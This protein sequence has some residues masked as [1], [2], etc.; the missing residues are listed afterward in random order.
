L[1]QQIATCCAWVKENENELERGHE[2]IAMTSRTL[3]ATKNWQVRHSHTRL[4]HLPQPK[5]GKS[6]T[7]TRD[8][9]EHPY[10]QI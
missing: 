2:K 5:I 4:G 7:A 6:D 8:K 3:A 10:L 1:Y 9:C